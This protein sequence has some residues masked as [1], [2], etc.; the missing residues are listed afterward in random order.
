M[1]GRGR[2]GAAL[3]QSECA[4]A[5]P[6]PALIINGTDAPLVPFESGEV[7]IGRQRRGVMT[8][9]RDSA[10]H[11]AEANGCDETPVETLLPDAAP[12]DKTRV[13]LAEYGGCTNGATVNL[14]I[15]EGGGHICPGGL[16]YLPKFIIG[17]SSRE[18][19]S[20]EVIWEFFTQ[21]RR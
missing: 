11:W 3:A 6:V 8:G 10:A 20:S 14:Y 12:R 21:Y 18:F 5:V 15:I 4:P 17:R 9:A 16:Q 1:I 2:I 13:R 19:E 7:R